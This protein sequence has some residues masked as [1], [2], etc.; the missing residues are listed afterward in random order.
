MQ[1]LLQVNGGVII[2]LAQPKIIPHLTHRLGDDGQL[3]GASSP[4]ML[5]TSSLG[6][7]R[8]VA[9]AGG[10]VAGNRA[11]G[12]LALH[13]GA[14]GGDLPCALPEPLLGD[15]LHLNGGGS[16]GCPRGELGFFGVHSSVKCVRR[17][18][19]SAKLRKASKLFPSRV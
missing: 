17:Q 13:V 1:F 6:A 9:L 12:E 7:I 4:R 11:L 15:A 19:H 10:G 5:S 18:E 3:A 2:A 14:A 8:I 16:R